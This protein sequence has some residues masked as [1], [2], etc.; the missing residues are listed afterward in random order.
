MEVQATFD[1]I[2]QNAV[3]NVLDSSGTSVGEATIV[4]D[5]PDDDKITFTV[6]DQTVLYVEHAAPGDKCGTDWFNAFLHPERALQIARQSEGAI[7][8]IWVAA[9]SKKRP[10]LLR[11]NPT[12][13]LCPMQLVA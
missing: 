6:A 8:E 2:I 3:A 9:G 5:N 7:E 12:R 11:P 1:V 4:Y 10:S 13:I